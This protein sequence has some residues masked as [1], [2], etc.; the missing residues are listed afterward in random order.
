MLGLSRPKSFFLG[1]GVWLSLGMGACS[2][3]PHSTFNTATDFDQD[4]QLRRPS[5]SQVGV[6]EGV[7]L[8]D[9]LQKN[10][11]KDALT[12][13]RTALLNFVA[14]HKPSAKSFEDCQ[15]K[16]HAPECAFLKERWADSW[17]EDPAEEVDNTDAEVALKTSQRSATVKLT[18]SFRRAHAKVINQLVKNLHDGKFEKVAG[19]VEGDFY[20]AFKKFNTWSPELEKLTQNVLA[21][22]ECANPELYTYL[23]LKGEE[24]FPD[25]QILASSIALYSKSD[26]CAMGITIQNKYVQIARFR[27]GLL[28]VMKEDCKSAE[29]I[30][31][32]LSKM[33]TNDYSTRALYWSAYCAKSESKRDEFLASFDELFKTNPLGFHTLSM[34]HGDSLLVEN[35]S[36]PIDPIVKTRTTREGQ[37][38][39]WIS[40]IEDLDQA[41]KYDAVN[42]MLTPVRKTPEY[43]GILEPGVRL[44]LSTFAYRSNDTISMFRMLD[45]VFRTQSE[46]VVD[47]TLKLFYPLRHLDAISA[48]VKKVNPLLI[49]AL[50]RQESAFQEK[51]HSRVG[52]IGLMQLMPAT[53]HLM[54]RTVYKKNLFDADTN[55]RLGV[56]YFEVLVDRYN[57]DVE[58][59]LAAYN[60]GADVVDRW[61]KRYAVKNRLLFLDL[62]PFAETRN[63]V[64]LIGRNYYWYSKIY[65]EQLKQAR[66]IAQLNEVE[67]RALKSQ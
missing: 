35:L 15:N 22:K 38:N 54:D 28:D 16:F 58:Y 43:L 49:A 14:S 39:L 24:F 23:G 55:V 18:K 26:Q 62:I 64:T 47:S 41:S 63:Y 44:Y 6:G 3:S 13:D 50:I 17:F 61:Q 45:S 4:L 31:S 5:A 59:A 29:P 34:T 56:K 60:A 12:P 32:R 11:K 66:G 42:R 8:S 53:A 36:K 37:M 1:L 67:F 65:S 51:A 10:L 25:N 9:A 40:F 27:G 2:S 52:A 19:Q 21:Q 33:G 30:L 46:Y 48:N 57:G 20:R 7:R